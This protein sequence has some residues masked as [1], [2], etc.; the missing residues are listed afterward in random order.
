MENIV[1]IGSGM[2]GGKLAEALCRTHNVTVIGEE[3]CGNYDRIHLADRLK[4]EETDK[5]WINSEEWYKDNGVTAYLGE[6][7]TGIDLTS[8]N[9]TTAKRT[10]SYDKLVFATGSNPLIPP[11]QGTDQDG[12]FCMRTIADADNIRSYTNDKNNVL[13]IG[14]GVLGLELAWALHEMG[15]SVTV[16]HLMSSLMETQLNSEAA[17]Y[18]QSLMTDAGLNFKMQAAAQSIKRTPDGLNVKFADGS[19]IFTDAVIINCGIRPRVDLAKNCGLNVGRGIVVDEHLRTSDPNVYAVGE[20]IEFGGKTFGILAP[21]Y[22]QIR[23]LTA[24]LNGENAVYDNSKLSYI[25]LKTKISAAAMGALEA[26][27]GDE[28]VSY[29]NPITK[30]YKKLI[31][32]DN[33]LKGAH[34]VG[35]NLNIEAIATYYT[36]K[37]PLPNRIEQLLFPGVH[38]EGQAAMSVYWPGSVTVCDCNGITSATIRDAI[39]QVGYDT[40]KVIAL[41]KA[42][43]SCGTC[44]S[45]VESIVDNSYDAIVIGSGL[46]GLSAAA[47]LSKGGKK[48]LVVERHDK[49]GGYA[50][51]F[52]RDG[53][54]FDVSLHNIGPMLCTTKAVFD[55]LGLSDKLT[56][57]PYNSFQDIIFPDHKFTIPSGENGFAD[58][59]KEL[60]PAEADNIQAMYDEIHDIRKGYEEFEQLS[61]TGDPKQ[62][63]NPMMALKYPQFVEL[64]DKTFTEF[65][66]RYI[67]DEKLKG[68]IGNFWWYGGLPPDRIASLIYIVTH[69]FYF[70]KAGGYIKGSAQELSNALVDIITNAGGKVI[71]NTEVKKILISDN[72]VDGIL[73]D[74]GQMYYADL[75]LSNSNAVDTFLNMCDESCIKKRIRRK[76]SELEYSLSAIQLYLGLDCDPAELGMTQHS[77]AV[78]SDYDHEKNY[79]YILDGEYD[80][81]FYSVSN[82]TKID[83]ETTPAGKGVITIISLDH[84]KNWESLSDYEYKKKKDRVIEAFIAKVEK[85]LPDIRKHIIVKELGTPK[86]MRRYTGNINGSIYGPS[87]I[88]EQSGMQ[89]L[90]P[91][92]SVG[93]LFIVGSTIYPGGGYPSVL[94]SGYKVANMILFAE[95][96]KDDE[97]PE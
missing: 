32:K 71:L 85:Q 17:G 27:E 28:E 13:V 66:D 57:I 76:V 34:L 95:Q 3:P 63:N 9:V 97:K 92:T 15:K 68:L 4:G 38:K 80:K 33:I 40:D 26:E 83:P 54:K 10:V 90:Q 78:F 55:D 93:G 5:F 37:L 49:A 42:S 43:S 51:A 77:F 74:D 31:I 67:K 64:A 46:G 89:R 24:I 25:K 45:R 52:T 48:V 56:Y 2:A 62:M 29:T 72:K 53:F 16:A 44:R 8:K 70:E 14:G 19:D 79:Q 86:T 73:C 39:R 69:V 94:S 82:Y 22:E 47:K 60:F 11:I 23:T 1:I 61:L 87:H 59:L 96:H 88:V 7:V 36:A 12:V 6:V 84:I 91:F 30:I 18:L 50:T 21:I 41:T 20:C 58:K 81:T 75:V 65:T 35:E